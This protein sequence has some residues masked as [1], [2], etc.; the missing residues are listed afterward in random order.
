MLDKHSTIELHPSSPA[1]TPVNIQNELFPSQ[2]PRVTK[3]EAHTLTAPRLNSVS[4]QLL[5]KMLSTQQFSTH[6]P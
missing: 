1:N 2:H 3:E 5:G 6:V 4:S